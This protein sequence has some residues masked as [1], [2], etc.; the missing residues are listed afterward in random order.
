MAGGYF[1]HNATTPLD[2]RVREAMLPWLGERWGNASSA[3]AW[4]RVAREAVER[5]RDQVASLLEASPAEIVFC[6]SG[7]E[8]NNAVLH[9][10]ARR[11]G[12]RGAVAASA[13]EHPS[14]DGMVELLAE[15]GMRVERVAPDG[16]GVVDPEAVAAALG[17]ETVLACLMLA[18]NEVG[19]LQAVAELAARCRAHG[20][21]LLCDAVQAVGKLPVSVAELGADYVSL[22]AHKFYGPLGAAALWVRGGAEF[23][24]YL[25]GGSQE[26]RRRAS[27]VNVAAVVGLGAA[28]E[29]AQREGAAWAAHAAG[30]RDRF[31]AGLAA[32]PD[33]VVHGAR[34]PRLPNTSHV[35]FL[36]VE[37]E[38]LMIRLD[39]AGFAVSSGSACS[40]GVIEPGRAMK[41]MGVERR[42]AIA[43]LRVSLGKGNTAEEVDDLLAALA[44]EVAELRGL[45]ATAAAS[46]G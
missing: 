30:L 27:T 39:L 25:I 16:D 34:V 45:A 9:A 14:I 41:A 35:A 21:P 11:A 5:A 12:F 40:S 23:S 33:V 2:P 4:G 19:T 29:L 17:G 18:N 22:G 20:V 28:A 31:E 36:G 10:V 37:N 7:T 44:R 38:A 15:R 13:F 6:A 8:A 42:E 24:P 46:S 32:L 1:D 3:H 26:R 43:S